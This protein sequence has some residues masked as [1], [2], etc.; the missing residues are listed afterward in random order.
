MS[1]VPETLC[2]MSSVTDPGQLGAALVSAINE[3]D[4]GAVVDLYESDAVLELPD[5]SAAR[6]SEEIRSFYA[7]LLARRP[8]FE[9]GIGLGALILGDL[10]LTN[11]QLGATATAE[12]AR[13]QSDGTWRWILDRPDV[14]IKP[15]PA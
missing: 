7:A 11:T 12:V 13:R 5:G 4:L 10:A 8:Q 15:G 9:P 2:N 14:M 1:V 6:G 3:G